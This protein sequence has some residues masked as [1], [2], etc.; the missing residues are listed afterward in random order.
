M[1][2]GARTGTL[3]AAFYVITLSS[4]FGSTQGWVTTNESSRRVTLSGVKARS[5]EIKVTKAKVQG[6]EWSSD[7]THFIEGDAQTGV[8]V[9]RCGEPMAFDTSGKLLFHKAKL[10]VR[11]GELE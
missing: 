9:E 5:G 1:V 4:E 7:R 11:F 2:H 8:E 3:T 6:P 10:M